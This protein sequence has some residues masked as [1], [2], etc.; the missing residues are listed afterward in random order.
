MCKYCEILCSFSLFVCVYGCV[1]KALWR[2]NRQILLFYANTVQ[3]PTTNTNTH[4]SALKKIKKKRLSVRLKW[5][6]IRDIKEKIKE[7]D[8]SVWASLIPLFQTAYRSNTISS[9]DLLAHP[10]SNV[11]NQT[12]LSLSVCK[13]GYMSSHTLLNTHVYVLEVSSDA[14]IHIC[15]CIYSAN[16]V[17][18][19]MDTHVK[20]I[21]Y[22][23]MFMN[24][25]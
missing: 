9:S 3:R 12:S 23:K 16:Q 13:W 21:I 15:V 18:L 17:Y 4:T 2:L 11:Q 8:L 20:W 6:R 7:M 1:R 24:Q 14:T 22:N 25:N 19:C 5:G 10:Y